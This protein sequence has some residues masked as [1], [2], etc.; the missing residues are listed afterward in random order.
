[1]WDLRKTFFFFLKNDKLHVVHLSNNTVNV[2][3]APITT[4]IVH[5]SKITHQCSQFLICLNAEVPK[6]ILTCAQVYIP[7]LYVVYL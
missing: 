4:V 7:G 2:F 6:C 5:K 3:T 1:M